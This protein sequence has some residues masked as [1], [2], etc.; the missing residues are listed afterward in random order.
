MITEGTPDDIAFREEGTLERFV[1]LPGLDVVDSH[2]WSLPLAVGAYKEGRFRK[3]AVMVMFDLHPK[4]DFQPAP[5]P[6]GI[7]GDFEGYG[8]LLTFSNH[9]AALPYIGLVDRMIIVYP[10]RPHLGF[11]LG[12]F[13]PSTGVLMETYYSGRLSASMT[14]LT[15]QAIGL[16]ELE[17]VIEDARPVPVTFTPVQHYP[18]ILRLAVA[19]G[20]DCYYNI[21]LDFFFPESDYRDRA[22]GLFEEHYTRAPKPKYTVAATSTEAHH[23]VDVSCEQMKQTIAEV[24]RIMS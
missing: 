17:E 23:L 9:L 13:D 20:K 19:R 22:L 21:D 7:E 15:R 4:E 10:E 12:D 3:P 8:R 11:V 16:K 2:K 5:L 24:N 14:A 1:R 6:P 18:D